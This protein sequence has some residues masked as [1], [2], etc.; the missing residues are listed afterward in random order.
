MKIRELYSDSSKW[1]KRA[2]ARNKSGTEVDYNDETAVQ[3]CLIGAL[4]H[5]YGYKGDKWLPPFSLLIKEFP[6]RDIVDFNNHPDTT[7][8]QVKELVDRLDI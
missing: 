5:C 8:E 7:F 4:H 6:D 2:L 1:I 3:W